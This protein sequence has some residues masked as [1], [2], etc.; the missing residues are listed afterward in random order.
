MARPASPRWRRLGR[1]LFLYPDT[2]NVYLLRSGASAL[3]VDCGTG[4]WRAHL[5]A[6]GVS[7]VTDIVLTHGHRDQV[8]GL[9]RD[10][11]A[12]DMPAVHV[13]SG[14]AHL[15][16]PDG[17]ASFWDRYQ[18]NGCPSSYAAPRLPVPGAV[19][20]VGP[21]TEL[22]VGGVRFCAIP[23]PG[24]TPG[25]LTYL[26]EW[27]GRQ[28]AFCGDAAHAG[29]R[30]WQPYHLEWDHWT[31]T[32][33]LAAWHGLERLQ[34]CH[35]DLLLP[36]QGPAVRAAP[37]AALRRLQDRLMAMIK[38]KGSVCP[39]EP[40]RWL[41]TEP[42]PSGAARISSHLYAFGG[43]GYLL[44][45]DRDDG[46]V[47]D[48]TLPDMTALDALCRELGL[49]RISAATAS[50]YHLDH[51][52]GFA[53]LARTR[54]T[55]AWL[56]PRVAEPLIDRDRLDVPWLPAASLRV[57][58]LLPR[59]GPFRWQEY[60]FGSR[61]LAGQ[62]YWH[63]AFDTVVDDRHVLF[64]GDSF[65]PPTRWN[66]TGGFCA[67][68]R[69]R[70]GEGFAASAKA[71]L[72]LAPDIVCNGHR[73]M[74]HFTRSHYRRIAAWAGRAE[75][76]VRDLCPSGAWLADYDVHASRLEPFVMHA[77]PG[78]RVELS[79][80]HRNHHAAAAQL[81]L[82]LALPPGW[83]AAPAQRSVRVPAGRQRTIRLALAIPRSSVAGRH[84]IAADVDIDGQLRAE[85]CVALVDV[86]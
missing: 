1:D 19:A 78:Q 72:D 6:L 76:A 22:V 69:S 31:P 81:R 85:A 9:Y 53:H 62:T 21:D 56:H 29:G 14:D 60:R 38:A 59:R 36:S 44:L 33:A 26:V 35:I 77:R 47:I 49:E 57:D 32:G 11:P 73:G 83:K 18:S 61:D 75:R 50:H 40:A 30:L 86:D 7:Q 15:L 46:F 37:G 28:L 74:Y 16:K 13:P 54:G 58:R 67:F 80:A 10:A 71:I 5:G 34:A 52:D 41:D 55:Q 45:S 64:S 66:G 23:T 48:P 3:C 51:S 17:L 68:N 84:V 79:Y 8:C 20:D 24:H 42:T 12:G 25:A 65:Q 63:A 27:H 2:C 70:F 43:N 82:S 39:G 4:A